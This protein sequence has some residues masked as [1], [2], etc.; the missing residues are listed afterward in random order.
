MVFSP[1]GISNYKISNPALML[2]QSDATKI[3][4]KFTVTIEALSTDPETIT[5]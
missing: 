1:V 2:M 5:Q 4:Q 3:N